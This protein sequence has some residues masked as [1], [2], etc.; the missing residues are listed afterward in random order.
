MK[1]TL[2]LFF[3]FVVATMGLEG[4]IE[5]VAIL[6]KMTKYETRVCFF[7]KNITLEDLM[8]FDMMSVDNLQATDA[9]DI[10]LKIGCL[11]ACL[12]EKKEMMTGARLNLDKIKELLQKH[13]AEIQAFAEALNPEKLA[14]FDRLIDSCANQV[15][16]ITNKCEVALRFLRCVNE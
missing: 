16:T 4:W 14:G 5:R 2:L 9:Q 10:N 3:T 1:L 8:K 11:L 15:E 12:G 6:L 7:E 13:Y